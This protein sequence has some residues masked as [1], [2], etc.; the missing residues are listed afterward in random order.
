MVGTYS[1]KKRTGV[2]S[3]MHGC[4]VGRVAMDG[5]EQTR[6]L[7]RGSEPGREANAPRHLGGPLRAYLDDLR[8]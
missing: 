8:L 2:P 4:A 6:G 5:E 7:K 1:L 3:G